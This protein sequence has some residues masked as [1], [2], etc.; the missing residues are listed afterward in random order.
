MKSQPARNLLSLRRLWRHA[1]TSFVAA[2]AMTILSSAHAQLPTPIIDL[3]FD[4]GTGNS[5]ANHGSAGGTLVRTDPIPYWTNHVPANVG[6]FSGLDFGTVTGNYYVESPTNFPQL[7]SL[8]RFTISGWVNCRS[9]AIGGGGNRVVA[10]NAPNSHGVD[11]VF[12]ADGSLRIG[13]NQ[14]PDATAGLT[15]ISSP[16]KITVDA[17]ASSANWRFFAVTYDSTQPA[18][19]LKFYFGS[20]A[21]DA[22]LDVATNYFRGAVGT[23]IRPLV[24]GHFNNTTRPGALNR[25][26]RGLIDEVKIFGEALTAEQILTVQRGSGATAPGFTA[27]PVSQTVLESQP[28]SFTAAVTGA[29]PIFA[30]WQRDGD[31]IPGA[32][33]LAYSISAASVADNGAVFRVVVSNALGQAIS[34]NAILTVIAD[35][36]PP[37]VLSVESERTARNLTNL[38]VTFSE[39]VDIGSAEDPGNYSLDDGTLITYDAVLQ[40]DQTTVVLRVDPI[41]PEG[42]HTLAISGIFDR[43][44]AANT[45]AS[46]NITFTGPPARIPPIIA[47]R[48]EEGAGTTAANTGTAGGTL[49]LSSPVPIWANNVPVGLGSASSVDFGTTTGNYFVESPT[50]YPQLTGLT[51]FT[52]A[53]WV[54]CRN[55]TE[56][57]GGNRIVTW[58]NNGGNGVDL[59]YHSDGSI[60]MG[61]NQWPD[62]GGTPPQPRSSADAITTD[63][64]AG[65]ANW[66]FFAVTYDGTA[67]SGHVKYYFGSSEADATLDGAR[68]YPRGAIAPN[69][70]RL[71]IGHFNI[72]T[73]ANALNRM[74]RGLIDEVQVF[75]DALSLEEIVALQR[76]GGLSSP[77]GFTTEPISQTLLEGQPAVFSIVVTGTP[78][79]SVQW[80]RNGDDIPG[81]NGLT[82][83]IPAVSATDNGDTFR[84]VVSSVHGEA[85]SSNAVL[86]VIADVIAPT[87]V[88][89]T[90]ARSA[91]N[92]TNLTVEFSE[93]VD[94]GSATDPGNYGINNGALITYDAVL[95]PDQRTVVLTIDPLTPDTVHTLTIAN[96]FD[97]AAAANQLVE[98]NINFTGPSSTVP[99][100][101]A[102]RFEEGTGTSATN[103]GTLGGTGTFAQQTSF[104]IFSANV[105]VGPFAPANSVASVDFGD[106]AAG[107]GARA[108]D[109]VTESGPSGTVGAM[110]SFTISGWVNARNLN[111][112]FGGN[113]IAF[114]LA[115]GNGPG[116]DLVQLSSGALRIGV[117]Q[118]PDAAGGGGPMSTA[119]KI[120]ADPAAGAGNWVFFAVT[121]DSAVA[122]GEIRYYFGKPDQAAE[123]DLALP[124]NRGPIVTSGRLTAGNFS[125]V[126]TPA[127]TALG[128]NGP[129]R[130]FRGLMDELQ[131]FDEAFSLEQIRQLQAAAPA[132]VSLQASRDG[133]EIVISWESATTFQLQYRDDAA[134]GEWHDETT[135]PEVNGNVRTVRLP[136]TGNARFYRL[137]RP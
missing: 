62:A 34:S 75:D 93:P 130:V 3:R 65:A 87:V 9:S 10:W 80:Q 95:Q 25:M 105:P 59:V 100:L 114:A 127:R 85:T 68:D 61:I 63:A 123:L 46:T 67:A 42:T 128:P 13:I 76:P 66:R 39:P 24:I 20:E 86:T 30:Q 136:F 60:Q 64:N 51:R 27:E 43:S 23:G 4:E 92:L 119:G 98:T 50:N 113:R 81:A 111:E 124:Y 48:F 7:A 11:L 112:G 69:I 117:N 52:I 17:D 36:I 33:A 122:G 107:E 132:G 58:I 18:E 72:A 16:G 35:V 83:S 99:P 118:W 8:T 56:G 29:P 90:A 57:P 54:N 70:N 96:V 2:M 28:V 78:P 89:V 116:F 82:Y 106:I 77:P 135:A 121:Y 71:C 53:G 94:P 22:L 31:D 44:A 6:G 110:N 41:T 120:T 14:W 101:V 74:F 115:S 1:G 12:L 47:V 133:N 103:I 40:P 19:H 26:F 32:N 137:A 102:L 129:S 37:T 126:D 88:S 73:R 84:A 21:E 15:N 49:A 97:R 125:V 109:L 55:N 108:I 91:R 38:T 45:L 5:V 104:P 79:L 134:Q 131:V